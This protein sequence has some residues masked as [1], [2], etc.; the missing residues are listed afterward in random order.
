[1][2]VSN[3]IT[4]DPRN[5][6]GCRLCASFIGRFWNV[7]QNVGPFE[8]EYEVLRRDGYLFG[9][10]DILFRTSLAKNTFRVAL[11]QAEKTG[12][13]FLRR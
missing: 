6:S 13:P 5:P 11:Q 4:V 8:V 12:N 2:Y 9:V 7:S 3:V 1:M 10:T